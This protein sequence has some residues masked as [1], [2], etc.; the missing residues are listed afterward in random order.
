MR[1]F[2]LVAAVAGGLATGAVPIS[3]ASADTG[4]AQPG[5]YLS[6]PAAWMVDGV[7]RDQKTLTIRYAG[8]GCRFHATAT[9][10]VRETNHTVTI[11][12][13]LKV[14]VPGRQP[15][16]TIIACPAIAGFAHLP[17]RL[18]APVAGRALRGENPTG[19]AGTERNEVCGLHFP[20]QAI[21]RLIGLGPADALAALGCAGLQ[22]RLVGHGREIVGERPRPG[23]RPAKAVAV[24]L[25][26]GR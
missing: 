25:V 4:P 2:A 5:Q 17:I 6:T 1:A 13:T 20:T 14:V 23:T 12:L 9:T 3:L 7:S 18:H 11:D 22:G 10:Q 24:Q 21:P 26:E 19:A 15:D 8:G 16:G